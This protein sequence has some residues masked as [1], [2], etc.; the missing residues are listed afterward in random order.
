[1]LIQCCNSARDKW[2]CVSVHARTHVCAWMSFEAD[3]SFSFLW[4][5]VQHSH[6]AEPGCDDYL[7]SELSWCHNC[8]GKFSIAGPQSMGECIKNT[9][10]VHLS[11]GVEVDFARAYWFYDMQLHLFSL[12]LYT[13]KQRSLKLPLPRVMKKSLCSCSIMIMRLE[14]SSLE[15]WNI[16]LL[17]LSVQSFRKHASPWSV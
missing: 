10:V 7:K 3:S 16:I 1:M 8:T 15:A 4:Q 14:Q 13:G 11:T 5:T 2:A 12:Q 9:K 6:W 17:L